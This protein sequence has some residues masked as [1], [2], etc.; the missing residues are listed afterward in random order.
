MINKKNIFQILASGIVNSCFAFGFIY[1]LAKQ[2]SL[3]EFGYFGIYNT[4]A[5]L[6][7]LLL[8][9]SS[10]KAF[11]KLQTENQNNDE[12]FRV[13]LRHHLITIGVIIS[14]SMCGLN[15]LIIGLAIS[16]ISIDFLSNL[17]VLNKKIEKV[18]V[19]NFYQNSWK[20]VCLVVAFFTF[21]TFNLESL[22]KVMVSFS[23]LNFICMNWIIM[24]TSENS[25]PRK[26]VRVF[27]FGDHTNSYKRFYHVCSIIFIG[28][29]S[30][31]LYT[32]SDILMSGY[33][34]SAEVAGVYTFCF[35]QIQV[36][37]DNFNHRFK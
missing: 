33:F 6:L 27:S 1:F 22:S 34:I 28:T 2:L 20:I 31:Y 15:E 23:V 25:Y 24:R 8:N 14:L 18:S 32:Q 7:C 29:L 4:S 12:Y 5:I 36:Q 19:L 30:S 9:F 16:K 21:D 35:S 10:N 3:E 17:Y 37:Q 26:L 13:T 11:Q